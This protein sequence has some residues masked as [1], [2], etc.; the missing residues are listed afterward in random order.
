LGAALA[1]TIVTVALNAFN[2]SLIWRLARLQPLRSDT[3]AFFTAI[4]ITA[5]VSLAAVYAFGLESSLAG[6]ILVFG[7]IFVAGAVT[8]LVTLRPEERNL[9]AALVARFRPA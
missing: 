7:C 6:P 1:T 9:A 4:A 2:S 8:A 3:I 5:S